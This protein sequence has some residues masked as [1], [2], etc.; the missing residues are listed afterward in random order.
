M[1]FGPNGDFQ[2]GRAAMTATYSG[3]LAYLSRG[4]KFPWGVAPLPSPRGTGP[5]LDVTVQS[6]GIA[7]V[8][9][10]AAAAWDY[11]LFAAGSSGAGVVAR[12]GNLPAYRTPV[13]ER[14]W[15][16]AVGQPAGAG[17]LLRL[18]WRLAPRFHPPAPTG[19][20]H[21]FLGAPLQ[22]AVTAVLTGAESVSAA[23]AAYRAAGR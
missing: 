20:G 9:R 7:G 1:F 19:P 16:V 18:P 15:G 22:R 21:V 5:G 12:S 6:L 23:V 4:L 17:G 2:R 10:S 14:E 8:G 11:V 13:I 3:N